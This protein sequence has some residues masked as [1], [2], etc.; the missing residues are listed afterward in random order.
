[1][2]S[3]DP[4]L[5]KEI[6]EI[7]ACHQ[8]LRELDS[9]EAESIVGKIVEK[10]VEDVNQVWWWRSLKRESVTL[11]YDEADCF[12]LLTRLLG[13][14]TTEVF[15]IVTDDEPQPWLMFSGQ[16][17]SI[18][19]VLTELRFFEFFITNQDCS[20]LVFDTHHN[21]LVVVG[22]LIE[23]AKNMSSKASTKISR[24]ECI[25]GFSRIMTPYQNEIGSWST[26]EDESLIFILSAFASAFCKDPYRLGRDDVIALFLFVEECLEQG[27]GWVSEAVATG[28]LET[29]INR[30]DEGCI[31]EASFVFA[32]GKEA[33]DY[34]IAW[35]E[36][37]G[38]TK[39]YKWL[40][41]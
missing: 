37:L 20:W 28:F 30:Y 8:D 9:S 25:D 29:L 22:N 11:P 17:E 13:S 39:K 38:V 3:I 36:K 4:N 23:A 5:F 33:K 2:K 7:V 35:N 1:M 18:R 24:T 41:G 34:L 16:F 15:L 21:A 27:D 26:D 12:G 14:E 31:E 40:Q 6:R 32:I 19:T 10:F